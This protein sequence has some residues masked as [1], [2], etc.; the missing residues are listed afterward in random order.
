MFEYGLSRKQCG[1]IFAN[2]KSGKIKA[3]DKMIKWLYNEIQ[4]SRVLANQPDAEFNK[5]M[6]NCIEYIF[7]NDY[8]SANASFDNAF[9]RWNILHGS[10]NL[11]K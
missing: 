3:S 6:K 7:A 10:C 2:W 9:G 1:V 8:E 11:Y 4:D 5:S